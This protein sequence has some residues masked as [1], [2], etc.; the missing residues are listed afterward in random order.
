[1]P[2]V[3]YEEEWATDLS[4]DAMKAAVEKYFNETKTK[5]KARDIG[6]VMG[7]Q[8]SKMKARLKGIMY[9]DSDELPKR[10]HLSYE[11]THNALKLRVRLEENFG[12]GLFLADYKR[13]F[14]E[15][16]KFWV[17]GLKI[18]CPPVQGTG[19]PHFTNV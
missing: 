1:M 12:F 8:G 18:N 11:E 2:S 7:E 3:Y 14:L 16:L 9:M 5:V 6:Y 10:I 19:D 17:Y 13:M 15:S 4:V